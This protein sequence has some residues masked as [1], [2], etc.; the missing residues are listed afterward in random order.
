M[1]N[2]I[3]WPSELL[4]KERSLPDEELILIAIKLKE[5]DYVV[6]SLRNLSG[7][8]SE[9]LESLVYPYSAI[10]VRDVNGNWDITLPNFTIVE[11]EIPKFKLMEFYS[12]EPISL[13]L[14]EHQIDNNRVFQK[15]PNIE[16]I[17]TYERY[18]CQNY[19]LNNTIDIINTYTANKHAFY[20]I[21]PQF[22]D[23][24]DDSISMIGIIQR[25]YTSTYI[26]R[27][28]C[29]VLYTITMIACYISY[30]GSDFI[31][32]VIPKILSVSS[33]AKQIDLRLQQICYFPIQF[34]KINQSKALEET[35]PNHQEQRCDSNGSRAKEPPYKYYPDYIRFY[36]T[37]W[38]IVNDISFGLI[39]GAMLKDNHDLIVN[40]LSEVVTTTLYDK[41]INLTYI[42]ANN[43]LGIKLNHELAS[44]LSELFYWIIE[45]SYNSFIKFTSDKEKLSVF[46]KIVT[47]VSCILGASFGI[48]LVIDF[49]SLLF[50]HIY[51]FY[52]IS[53]KLYHWQLNTLISLFYLFCGKKR[54]VLRKRIDY[55]YFEIDELLLGTLLFIILAFL[56]PTVLSFYSSYAVIWVSTVY[57]HVILNSII[58][59]INHFPLFA[60]LLRIKDPKRLPGGITLSPK[61]HKNGRIVLTLKNSPLKVN[62]MFKPF[63]YSMNKMKEYY[64]SVT[65]VKSL[66]GGLPIM[67]Q[68][69]EMYDVLY[70]WLPEE[71]V[72]I[73]ETMAQ[74]KTCLP[75][76][77][78]KLE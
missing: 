13:I 41:M 36:N 51:L 16:K 1:S 4:R 48:S 10:G 75:G 20:N 46:L 27:I 21:Y 42:L 70:L 71:P 59:L 55:D 37:L 11:F 66:L 8:S 63:T 28:L 39:L 5:T 34:M 43:P 67:I 65:T 7:L 45:F 29:Y 52:H 9:L 73:Q 57:I 30:Y 74:L 77:S 69:N 54:N 68:M 44:F 6:I 32:K 64:F 38:L 40:T 22:G 47:K 17:M 25:W 72:N 58:S 53:R 56:M 15:F 62:S 19:Q 50:F 35:I 2:Y 26:H 60:F 18:Q 23:F 76:K 61:H 31:R 12:I 49:L 3:F 33:T 78:E 24:Q 14:S